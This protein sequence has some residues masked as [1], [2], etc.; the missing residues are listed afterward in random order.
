MP[1]AAI[2]A[3]ADTTL[4]PGDG[5]FDSRVTIDRNADAGT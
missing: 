4:W 3:M 1:S 5:L 2:G